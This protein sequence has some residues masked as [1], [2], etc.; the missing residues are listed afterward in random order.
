MASISAGDTKRFD[1]LS[2]ILT[3]MP[4]HSSP[5]LPLAERKEAA[6]NYPQKSRTARA[7]RQYVT[8]FLSIFLSKQVLNGLD[9]AVDV[10]GSEGYQYVGVP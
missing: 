8:V 4:V 7:A 10:A 1:A 3:A 2:R 6:A 5:C 9:Q